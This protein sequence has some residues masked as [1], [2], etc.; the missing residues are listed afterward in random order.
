MAEDGR[1]V[2]PSRA[3]LAAAA[4]AGVFPR[5]RL[6]VAGV[7]LSAAGAVGYLLT[8]QLAE[9]L[10]VLIGDGLQDA[11]GRRG[12]PG[13]VLVHGL[14]RGLVLILPLVLIPAV[15][16]VLAALAPAIAARRG[17]GSTS[18]PLPAPP[19]RVS[20]GVLALL[21][22]AVF[23]LLALVIVRE[24]GDA[25]ARSLGGPVAG[26]D[27]AGELI[28]LLVLAAGAT[29]VLAGLADLAL[30]RA[31][32]L[33]ALALRPSDALR[34]QRAARGDPRTRAQIR[35]QARDKGD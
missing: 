9:A 2:P 24:H 29:M 26:A 32:L 14:A 3:R 16:G 33:R 23:A 28:A 11:V 25:I 10:A 8:E 18:V 7:A 20:S 12:D 15:L 27:W 4:R 30:E 19:R 22:L 17:G 1:T 34:E 5:S 31:S 35:A 6:L 21:A 13:S